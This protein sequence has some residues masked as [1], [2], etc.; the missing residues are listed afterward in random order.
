MITVFISY[1]REGG[2]LFARS[3]TEHFLRK[4]KNIDLFYDVESMK[5]GDFNRQIYREIQKRD[6]VIL[7]LPK[8]AL[9]RCVSP[10]DWVRL[11]IA[12]ALRCRKPIIPLEME[13]FEW[14]AELPEDINAVRYK[15]G[16]RASNDMFEARMEKL[17]EMIHEAVGK[18][19]R[20]KK[21]PLP[22][23]LTA[24]AAIL[25]S[26]LVLPHF[27]SGNP[28]SGDV[29]LPQTSPSEITDDSPAQT[30]PSE[31]TIDSS[32][33]QTISPV[34]VSEPYL[35]LYGAAQSSGSYLW[36]AALPQTKSL[37]YW[38]S[39]SEEAVSQNTLRGSSA[40]LQEMG[41]SS[42]DAH[43]TLYLNASCADGSSF[44]SYYHLSAAEEEF[45]S[46]DEKNYPYFTVT[47]D[48]DSLLLE[49]GSLSN[50][51]K[52]SYE[53][54]GTN[55]MY[56]LINPTESCMN[57]ELPDLSEPQ[58]LIVTVQSTTGNF[59]VKFLRIS[60]AE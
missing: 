57:L 17:A 22:F 25:L 14:P 41:T 35:T 46:S 2:E 6:C 3:I 38:I 43:C 53:W 60:S 20:P 8:N 33:A 48:G 31:I 40:Y 47:P 36:R 23:V 44:T 13:G 16:M 11:E 49:L 34:Q 39:D 56:S 30:I 42:I 15:Q 1:R 50:T 18:K 5:T 37:D 7:L 26:A 29:S 28:A 51:L 24:A 12:Y 10:N 9:D 52:Y 45:T 58:W 32:P 54:L 4:Y 19:Y 55:H 21:N 27:L 59:T